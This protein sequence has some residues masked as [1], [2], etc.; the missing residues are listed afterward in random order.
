VTGIEWPQLV[1]LAAIL[2]GAAASYLAGKRAA[3][4]DRELDAARVAL[5]AS[6][7]KPRNRRI[8]R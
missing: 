2:T 8:S 6:L 1:I 7:T 5:A 4:L 3:A